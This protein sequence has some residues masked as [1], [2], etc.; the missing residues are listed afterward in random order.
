M[1]NP[2]ECLRLIG[3]KTGA[4]WGGATC[5]KT[6]SGKQWAGI[7]TYLF[8]CL[9][10]HSEIIANLQKY[11]KNST[12]KIPHTLYPDSQIITPYKHDEHKNQKN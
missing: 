5:P 12:L 1:T 7:P 4:Q 6:H 2:F 3:N 10:F 8:F 11:C 9:S